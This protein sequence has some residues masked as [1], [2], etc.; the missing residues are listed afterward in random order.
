MINV[1]LDKKANATVSK[2]LDLA[3][4]G[5]SSSWPE[6]EGLHRCK[7]G[8]RVRI[9]LSK[10]TIRI[11]NTYSYPQCWCLYNTFNTGIIKDGV[12]DYT[13]DF[14]QSYQGYFCLYTNEEKTQVM[15]QLGDGASAGQHTEY[16]DIIDGEVVLDNMN[17]QDLPSQ[18]NYFSESIINQI[19]IIE[20]ELPETFNGA[21]LQRYHQG[22]GLEFEE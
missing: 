2:T 12:V 18:G 22:P 4:G 21:Y 6:L 8:D 17:P 20:I 1:K 11:P 13:D 9:D 19:G 16:G 14:I 15:L 7:A 5:G 3:E 10:M